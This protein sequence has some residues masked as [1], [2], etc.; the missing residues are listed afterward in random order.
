[1]DMRL[2]SVVVPWVSKA[3][4][5]RVDTWT[6]L[7]AD[8]YS[9]IS[10]DPWRAKIDILRSD[11]WVKA[12]WNRWRTWDTVK[13]GEGLQDSLEPWGMHTDMEWIEIVVD[14]KVGESLESLGIPR[15]APPPT[16]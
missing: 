1:M 3:R 7:Q 2:S 6:A 16:W 5:E 10:D 8:W 13:W 12:P 15:F 9:S 14:G 4:Y 11:S